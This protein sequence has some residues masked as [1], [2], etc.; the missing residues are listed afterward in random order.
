[1]ARA[2]VSYLAKKL[3]FLTMKICRPANSKGF[4]TAGQ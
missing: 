3:I 4:M 1:L 2:L